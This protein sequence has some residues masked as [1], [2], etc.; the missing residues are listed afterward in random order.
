VRLTAKSPFVMGEWEVSQIVI[1]DA[2]LLIEFQ[3]D[4]AT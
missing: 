2:I 3:R 1:E 4:V